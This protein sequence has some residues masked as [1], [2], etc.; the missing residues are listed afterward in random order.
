MK[1]RFLIDL[2][3]ALSCSFSAAYSNMETLFLDILESHAPSKK[4]MVRG[5]DKQHMKRTLGK[6]YYDAS[7]IGK[8]EP[9]MQV[10]K[11][12]LKNTRCSTT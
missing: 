2:N 6:N 8:I 7:L 12:I 9:T 1:K 11:K 4:R 5:N 10:M 3:D